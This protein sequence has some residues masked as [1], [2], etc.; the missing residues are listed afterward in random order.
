MGT[1]TYGNYPEWKAEA[2]KMSRDFYQDVLDYDADIDDDSRKELE[3]GIKKI[4]EWLSELSKQKK[5]TNKSPEV[6]VWKIK[7]LDEIKKNIEINMEEPNECRCGCECDEDA[8]EI[9][10]MYQEELKYVK[11]WLKELK[12]SKK[13]SELE[14]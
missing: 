4:N 7:L 13:G 1:Y 14:L 5:D 11:R 10:E 8:E 6:L 9:Q 2:L 3:V 12:V